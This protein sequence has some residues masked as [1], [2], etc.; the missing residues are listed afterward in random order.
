MYFVVIEG[1]SLIFGFDVPKWL[2]LDWTS[3]VMHRTLG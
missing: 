3:H 1:V 2:S